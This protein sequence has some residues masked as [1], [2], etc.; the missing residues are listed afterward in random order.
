MIKRAL[1][2]V[3]DKTDLLPLAYKLQ[4]A[5]V[6]I[7]ATGKTH[8]YL[9]ANQ[10][11]ATSLSDYTH[12]PEVLGGRVK[13]LH[14]AIHAGLLADPSLHG[15]EMQTLAIQQIDLVV[16]NLYPFEKCVNSGAPENEIIENVDIGGVSLLRSA[17]KNFKNVCV[18]SDPSDYSTFDVNPTLSFRSK[19]ARKA[20]AR[21]ARYDCKIAEWFASSTSSPEA[22][23]LSVMK[24]NDF[25]YGENPHQNASFYSDGEFPLTKL[26]GKEL[27]YNNLLDLDSALSIVMNFTEPTCAIIK[28]TNPCGVASHK[29]SLE[30]AY[31]KALAAD[32]L[33]AFGGVVALNQIVTRNVAEKLLATFFEVIVAPGITQDAISLFSN[34]PNL[35]VLTYK[36]YA[37][38]EKHMLSLLGGFLVQ[39]GNTKLFQDFDIVTKREPT[40]EEVN[41]LIF[42]WKVCKYVKSNAIVT[43]HDYT[44]VG[45]GAGQMSRVKSVEIALEK[46]KIGQPLAMASDAF[47]PFADSIELAAKK[48]VASIIQPGG[49]I[50]DKEVIEAANHH[51]IAMIFTRMR[52]FRH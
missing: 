45:I 41:Q 47:F 40:N 1:I 34:K 51:N 6:E 25:R 33:S 5:N 43:A 15:P 14:P 22:L 10:I 2:S 12:Q 19:M 23:N 38:P 52:H 36:S 46:S 3:Y 29:S 30:Q 31:E 8:Q 37:V 27:S 49:S 11:R 32:S 9:L 20:F 17:A 18:L 13:T 50:R 28:H 48:G 16:V 44:T 26:Q 21:V 4:A 7:I 35:R 24:K 39:S 42:A